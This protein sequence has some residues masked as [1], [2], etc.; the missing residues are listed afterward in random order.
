MRRWSLLMVAPRVYPMTS[1]AAACTPAQLREATGRTGLYLM[2]R[3]EHVG[4][5]RLA[6]AVEL[7][8]VGKP[9]QNA[10]CDAAN[11][12][13][14]TSNK[15]STTTKLTTSTELTNNPLGV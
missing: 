5:V 13:T 6:F 4:Y 11:V 8:L 12:V 9:L 14:A 2:H 7:A 1:H 3:Q 15:L 10:H